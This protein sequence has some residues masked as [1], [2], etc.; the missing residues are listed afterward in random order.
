LNSPFWTG[1]VLKGLNVALVVRVMDDA[2]NS[3]ESARPGAVDF[4]REPDL[5][6][7]P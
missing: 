1:T 7:D 3:P 2:V 6:R 4:S 5:T